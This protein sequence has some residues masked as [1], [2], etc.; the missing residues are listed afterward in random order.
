MKKF[1]S[2]LLI[3]TLILASGMTALAKGKGGGGGSKKDKPS[4]KVE[5]SVSEESK[6]EETSVDES[7][8]AA[9][10]EA[11]EAEKT[12]EAEKDAA[13]AEEEAKEEDADDEEKTPEERAAKKAEIAEKKALKKEMKTEVKELKKMAKRAYSEEDIAAMEEKIEELKEKYPGIKVVPVENIVSKNARIKFDTPPVIKEG[14]T[15]VPVRALT[16]AFG[17]EVSWNEEEKQVVI[18]KEGVEMKINTQ[19]KLAYLNGEEVELD[20]SAE[21]MNGRTVVPLRFVV[22]SMGLD[23][24]WDEETGTIEIEEESSEEV[25][26]DAESTEEAPAVEEAPAEET[27]VEE[28]V[29]TPEA[30][31]EIVEEADTTTSATAA[32]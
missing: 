31:E 8:D 15:L 7:E 12:E 1:F 30:L 26:E 24:N 3:V 11:E 22:E 6:S 13:E 23:V 14:R 29:E 18:V 19:D 2:I 5:K 21:I 10:K 32:Q 16:E 28:T 17:A 25:T 27:V 20:A 4:K 9:E